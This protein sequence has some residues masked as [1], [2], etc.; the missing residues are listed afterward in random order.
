MLYLLPCSLPDLYI[1]I[2]IQTHTRMCASVY[3]Y[4]CRE[5]YVI[6]VIYIIDAAAGTVETCNKKIIFFLLRRITTRFTCLT[7]YR[8]TEHCI[9]LLIIIIILYY[10]GYTRG[11]C[12]RVVYSFLIYKHKP[13]FVCI[14][15]YCVNKLTE[16]SVHAATL[17]FLDDL[18]VLK[19][20]L[21]SYNLP[22]LRHQH[23]LR[24]SYCS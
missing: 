14:C 16:R 23:F 2:Y 18:S 22:Y 1:Y 20:T 11:H 15:V 9:I 3:I 17:T 13:I 24:N 5:Y 6:L 19:T 10:I 8:N 4:R 21:F 12:G 7:G